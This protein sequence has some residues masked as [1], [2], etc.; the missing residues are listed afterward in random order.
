[1]PNICE[2]QFSRMALVRLSIPRFSTS[3]MCWQPPRLAYNVSTTDHPT[4]HILKLSVQANFSPRLTY[5][6]CTHEDVIPADLVLT[7]AED[8]SKNNGNER[9]KSQSP[10][11]E[12]KCGP[13]IGDRGRISLVECTHGHSDYADNKM[14]SLHSHQSRCCRI[15]SVR[16][17]APFHKHLCRIRLVSQHRQIVH[18]LEKVSTVDARKGA[19]VVPLIRWKNALSCGAVVNMNEGSIL[20]HM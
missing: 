13:S 10:H 16:S 18:R 2:V 14:P 12:D 7:R 20:Q 15:P 1:M 17:C 5:P 9:N 8:E 11:Q 6:G 4:K 19:W 3:Q